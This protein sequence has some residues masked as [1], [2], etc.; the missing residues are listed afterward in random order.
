MNAA[1]HPGME[2]GLAQFHQVKPEGEIDLIKACRDILV[3]AGLSKSLPEHFDNNRHILD[4]QNKIW[5]VQRFLLN[6]YWTAQLSMCPNTINARYSLLANGAAEAWLQ[7]FRAA[8]LNV[9]IVNELPR[10]VA[11]DL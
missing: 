10:A 3:E 8:V 6:R 1:V 5:T 2:A 9:I 11:A 4:G 7:M